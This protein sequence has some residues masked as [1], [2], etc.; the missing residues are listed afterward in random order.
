MNNNSLHVLVWH[1]KKIFFFINIFLFYL[2]ILDLL[3]VG[4]SYSYDMNCGF[5][6]LTWLARVFFY[7]NFFLS[8]LSFSIGVIKN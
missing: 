1:Y 8:I 4:L 7:F 2:L 5:Y 6:E 3:F